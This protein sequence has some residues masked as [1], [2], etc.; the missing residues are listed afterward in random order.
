MSRHRCAGGQA[1]PLRLEASFDREQRLGV[2]APS[3]ERPFESAEGG[4]DEKA[5]AG[6]DVDARTAGIARRTRTRS[7]S[8]PLAENATRALKVAA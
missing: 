7:P 6:E 2:V 1:E 3:A 5:G 8:S 4:D